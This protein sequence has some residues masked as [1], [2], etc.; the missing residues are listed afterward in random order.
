MEN[1][2]VNDQLSELEQTILKLERERQRRVVMGDWP[3]VAEL[4]VQQGA[5]YTLGQQWRPAA[6]VFAEVAA[7]AAGYGQ[8][9]Q[10][11]QAHFLRGQLLARVD[12]AAQEALL[13]FQT[14]AF[15]FASS[16]REAEALNSRYQAMVIQATMGQYDLAI[17]EAETMLATQSDNKLVVVELRCLQAHCHWLATRPEQSLACLDEAIAQAE[18][19]VANRLKSYRQ[20]LS[21]LQTRELNLPAYIALVQQ[22]QPMLAT[23]TRPDEQLGGAAAALGN[24]QLEQAIELAGQ[25]QQTAA[26]AND[27]LRFVRYLLATLILAEAYYRLDDRP[28]V[29]ATLLS[30]RE[31]FQ[32]WL[33]ATMNGPLDQLL[34]SLRQ[35][36]A[37]GP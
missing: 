37:E 3:A 25:A 20:L 1:E 35:R 15:C 8:S 31:F 30:G 22:L 23:F 6:A 10:Q 7:I 14:A 4:Y 21:L 24:N 13:A 2:Q 33:G 17:A 12:G 26:Q 36:W 28:A 5:A 16:G 29:E 18:G 34:A 9:D 32:Q 11:G 27:L 19:D